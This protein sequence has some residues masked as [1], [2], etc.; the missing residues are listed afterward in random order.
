M[1]LIIDMAVLMQLYLCARVKLSQIGTVVTNFCKSVNYVVFISG[2]WP[3]ANKF[4]LSKIEMAALHT[5]CLCQ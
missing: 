1:L 2:S 5:L 3:I 4:I